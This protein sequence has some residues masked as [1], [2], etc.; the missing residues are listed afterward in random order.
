MLLRTCFE[1]NGTLLFIQFHR[2]NE[3][4]HLN[5]IRLSVAFGGNVD[6]GSNKR[7]ANAST[8]RNGWLEYC[9][10]MQVKAAQ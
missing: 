10:E 1:R 5:Y 2:A 8:R 7:L 3:P 9:I 6:K 4:T